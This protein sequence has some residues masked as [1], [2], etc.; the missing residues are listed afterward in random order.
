M[1]R[2][3]VLEWLLCLVAQRVLEIETMASNRFDSSRSDP[4]G[5][6]RSHHRRKCQSVTWTATLNSKFNNAADIQRFGE[7]KR[8]LKTSDLA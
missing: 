1:F 7:E 2:G 4:E 5:L 3:D 6:Q 8:S